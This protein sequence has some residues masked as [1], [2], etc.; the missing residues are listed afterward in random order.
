[1]TTARRL[2]TAT[3][4]T[5]TLLSLAGCGSIAE[6][7]TEEV[8]ERALEAEGSGNVE[9]DL[10]NDNGGISV[11]TSEGSFSVGGA[12]ELPDT[13]PTEIPPPA[14]AEVVSSIAVDD[15]DTT[16]FNVN[17]IASGQPDPI[18]DRLEAS[19]TDAGF[20]LADQ[21]SIGTDAASTRTFSFTNADWMGTVA[22]ATGPDQTVV[23]YSV[24]AVTE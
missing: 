15:A 14:D 4:A 16:G 24:S 17:W 22:V 13:F 9:L 12:R 2:L 8:A 18:A 21:A 11:E 1:M 5:L 3:I 6:N 7:L 19:F 10:D 23:N 20:A